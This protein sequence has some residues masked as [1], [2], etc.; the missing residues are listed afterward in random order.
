MLVIHR[1]KEGCIYDRH[2]LAN[3]LDDITQNQEK[4]MEQRVATL[5]AKVASQS[6]KMDAIQRTLAAQIQELLLEQKQQIRQ[7]MQQEFEAR[8]QRVE[9]HMRERPPT[10]NIAKHQIEITDEILGRGAWGEVRIGVYQGTRVAI[11]KM[12]YVIISDYNRELFEREMENTSSVRHPNLVLFIGAVTTG[13]LTIV[14]ELLEVSVRKLLE[15]GKLKLP[16]IRPIGKDVASALAYLHSLADPIIHRSVSS[17]NV[18][19]HAKQ[20]GWCAKLG[21]F[22]SA[23]FL[24]KLGTVGQGN[25]TYSA[26]EVGNPSQQLQ[27]PKMDV[28]SF[29]ILLLEMCVGKLIAE[30]NLDMTKSA[31][32]RWS[33][34]DHNKK[35][36][37]DWAVRCTE[38]DPNDR[39]DMVDFVKQLWPT[40]VH[41][42]QV[43][44]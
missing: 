28:Y 40:V 5:E 11:K 6:V 23:N 12:H 26:P 25:A 39:P 34:S 21:D 17:G 20:D 41:V 36:L 2:S 9:G 30:H 24:A 29:G 16:D 8:I 3:Y 33:S 32:K 35:L 14:S 27:D 22:A 31:V 4:D 37:G 1:A 44:V 7:E 38:R 18:L 19:L 10:W 15:E 13:N 43:I 42:T